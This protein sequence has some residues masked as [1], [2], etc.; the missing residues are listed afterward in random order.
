MLSGWWES[1]SVTDGFPATLRA[2]I[3]CVV[4]KVCISSVCSRDRKPPTAEIKRFE[5]VKVCSKVILP[6]SVPVADVCCR[7]VVTYRHS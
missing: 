6:S 5:E 2:M 7:R 4:H 1:I 3:P